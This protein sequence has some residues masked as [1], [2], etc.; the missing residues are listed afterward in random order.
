MVRKLSNSPSTWCTGNLQ[1]WWHVLCYNCF[2]PWRITCCK[3][4]LIAEGTDTAVMCLNY[5]ASMTRLLGWEECYWFIWC[6]AFGRKLLPSPFCTCCSSSTVSTVRTRHVSAC[7]LGLLHPSHRIRWCRC[8]AGGNGRL[9]Q[10]HAGRGTAFPSPN[11]LLQ[12]LE[13]IW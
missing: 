3:M 9:W 6:S 8:C 10:L 13:L 2:L 12:E 4:L 11:D 1:L 7:C 5:F